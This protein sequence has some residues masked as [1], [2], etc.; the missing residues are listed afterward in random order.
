ME[1]SFQKQY[2][3]YFNLISAK[4]VIT[5]TSFGNQKGIRI[6]RILELEL[7]EGTPE[8]RE[9]IGKTLKLENNY[10]YHKLDQFGNYLFK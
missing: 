7:K 6:D 5:P 8:I 2:R 10:K 4:S 1:K 9:A 3:Q